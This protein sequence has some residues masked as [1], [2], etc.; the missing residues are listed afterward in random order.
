MSN[1]PISAPDF[2]SGEEP[3]D[4]LWEAAMI[5]AADAAAAGDVAAAAR[6]WQDAFDLADPA[7]S[8]LAE[9]DP[10]RA[11][12]LAGLGMA[13]LLT[14][15][16]AEAEALL[17]RALAA[18]DASEGWI[19]R[20]NPGLRSR[21]SA[22]HFRVERRFAAQHAAQALEQRR[23]LLD[24]GRSA[25]LAALAAL[26][27]AAGARAGARA[28]YVQAIAL[29]ERAISRRAGGVLTLL[30]ALAEVLERLDE[31]AAAE[32][33]RARR[34]A[35]LADPVVDGIDRFRRDGPAASGDA[36]SLLAAVLL[37]PAAVLPPARG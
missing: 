28:L 25:T 29:R 7:D 18:W 20:M 16:A 24:V 37:L 19:A 26:P 5:A 31:S 3:A 2:L 21:S 14:G 13:R 1:A 10:R 15:Q 36:P 6:H 17:A 27:A 12:S 30:D 11:A 34:R 35:A 8:G 32:E 33:C 22:Q 9:D 4:A 23:R